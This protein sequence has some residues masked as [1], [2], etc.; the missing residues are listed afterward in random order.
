MRWSPRSFPV[1]IRRD[2]DEAKLAQISDDELEDAESE[3]S[4]AGNHAYQD[5]RGFSWRDVEVALFRERSIIDRLKAAPDLE[6]AAADFEE[7]RAQWIDE[8]EALFDLD[9]GVAA[10]VIALSAMGAVPIASC[11]AG[12]FGGHH[13]AAYPYIAFFVCGARVDDVMSYA[14]RAGV[15]LEAD[16]SGIAQIF[17]NDSTGLTR[18]AEIAVA[19]HSKAMTA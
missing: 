1:E 4:V 15:G 16:A 9:V 10:A 19:H 8:Q 5:L 2:L 17:S 14:M 3:G 12:A 11:S 18:F 13:V 6:A 7:T